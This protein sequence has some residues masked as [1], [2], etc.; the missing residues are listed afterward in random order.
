MIQVSGLAIDLGAFH[1]RDIELRIESGEYMVLLGPTG[2]GKSVL[3][4]CLAGLLQPRAGVVRIDGTDVTDWYPEERNVGFVPQ[5]YA[6]FPTMTVA[7]NLAYGLVAHGVP[8]A[9]RCARVA[10]LVEELGLRGLEDR[11]PQHLSGGERQR[12]ALGRAL[13]TH[14]RIVLLDEPLS[15]LDEALRA[16]LAADLR[17]VQRRCRGTFLHVCHSFDEAAAVADRVAIM[18]D[19]RIVQQGSLLEVVDRPANLFVARFSRARN[20]FPAR[21]V[22][23]AGG[24]RLELAGGGALSS[25]EAAPS[26][27]VIASVRPEAIELGPADGAPDAPNSLT[28]TVEEVRR[29]LSLD[30]LTCSAGVEVIVYERPGANRRRRGDVVRLCV[31]PAAI[32]LFAR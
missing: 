16:D 18:H 19:G 10:D 23:V 26:G 29:T 24:C 27:D 4:E 2:A 5:D 30:E 32:R 21:A 11:T 31:P 9:K 12:V 17:A 7:E 22:P 25:P 3:L 14:P 13:A 1:L 15:A 20:L 6:L 8:P 28:A